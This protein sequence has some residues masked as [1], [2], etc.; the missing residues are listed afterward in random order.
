M[1]RGRKTG[2]LTGL[3]GPRKGR[4][5]GN[6][7]RYMAQAA[8]NDAKAKLGVP[9]GVV[10]E[11]ASHEHARKAAYAAIADAPPEPVAKLKA[12]KAAAPPRPSSQLLRALGGAA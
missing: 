7:V 1:N 11:M 9:M 3:C 6:V 2:E 4:R 8:K 5:I 12:L 10:T